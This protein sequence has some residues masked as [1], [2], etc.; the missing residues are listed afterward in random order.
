MM[1][2]GDEYVQALEWKSDEVYEIFG[3]YLIQWTRVACLRAW[4][5]I[6]N[7]YEI[8]L[9]LIAMRSKGTRFTLRKDSYDN[10]LNHK[11]IYHI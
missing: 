8:G 6:P 3:L 9:F 7:I 5:T 10:F 4:E 1:L 11:Y 2:L